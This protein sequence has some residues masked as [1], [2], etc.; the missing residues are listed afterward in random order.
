SW[1]DLVNGFS[2]RLAPPSP[3]AGQAAA[4]SLTTALK[5]FGVIGVSASELISYPYW[6][7]EKGYRRF[8]GKRD[9]TNGWGARARG[10]MNVMRWDAWCSMLIYTT[11]TVAFYLLGAAVLKR[12]KLD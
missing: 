5:T 10:W 6:C 2:F 11:A 9:G 1:Q 7:I 8:T 12:T 3:A 4:N